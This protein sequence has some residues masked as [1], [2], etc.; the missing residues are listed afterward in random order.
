LFGGKRVQRNLQT[1][2]KNGGELASK[3]DKGKERLRGIGTKLINTWKKSLGKRQEKDKRTSICGFKRRGGA[4]QP[5]RS[6]AMGTKLV[7]NFQVKP[8]ER[9]KV[10]QI[11]QG[12]AK[13]LK[14][15][16]INH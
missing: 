16:G 15:I 8:K 14:T 6:E 3:S 13:L 7:C 1:L 2:G 9:K 12:E 11:T 10:V 5:A 4:C